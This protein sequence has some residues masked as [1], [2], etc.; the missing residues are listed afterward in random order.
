MTRAQK[1]KRKER[2]AKRAAAALKSSMA[3][4]RLPKPRAAFHCK[5]GTGRREWFECGGVK[6]HMPPKCIRYVRPAS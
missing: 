5:S 4:S 1:Q 2:R 6:V 3:T